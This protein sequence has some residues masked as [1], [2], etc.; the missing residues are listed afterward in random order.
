VQSVSTSASVR[1]PLIGRPV[2]TGQPIQAPIFLPFV[3]SALVPTET[4]PA[5]VRWFAGNQPMT[6]LLDTM[7]DIFAP[8][9]GGGAGFP[10]D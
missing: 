3:R 6:A 2:H 7:R 5:P 4:M 8:A 10:S 1:R 9:T